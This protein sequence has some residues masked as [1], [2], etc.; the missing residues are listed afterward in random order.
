VLCAGR[1]QPLERLDALLIAPDAPAVTLA[2]Q[3]PA[4][5]LL[6]ELRPA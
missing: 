5:L 1:P 6:A 4:A 3:G 2:V